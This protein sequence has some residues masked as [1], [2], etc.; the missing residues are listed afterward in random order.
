MRWKINMIQD[1]IVSLST[2]LTTQAVS[3]IRFSGD[4]AV[5]I[6]ETLIKKDLSQQDH[7]L[8]Y[9]FIHEPHTNL[10]VDEVIV[11]VMKGPHSYT[12]EDIVEIQC[13]GGV[14]VTQKILGL[15]LGLGARLAYNGEF[16]QRAVMNGRIDL[17]QAEAINELVNADSEQSAQLAIAGL[18][19]SLKTLIDPLKEELLGIIAHIE[20]NIDYPEYDIEEMTR[21]TLLP[22]C[23]DFKDKLEVIVH[24]SK[25]GIEMKNGIKTAIIGKPN[26]GKSSLLNALLNEDKAIVTEIPGTTRDVVEGTVRLKNV[27]LHLLDTAGIRQ[28]DDIVEKLGIDKTY[29]MIDEAELILFLV[30]AQ[31]GMDDEERKLYESID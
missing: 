23:T 2:A 13:H 16:T 9:G 25:S 19:G 30:D 10:V 29:K 12:R 24:E 18:K 7:R 22:L 21:L 31:N 20:V 27:S 6:A 5:E 4:R 28:S 8:T 1:T 26:V 15:V 17:S 11:L 14:F 3:I